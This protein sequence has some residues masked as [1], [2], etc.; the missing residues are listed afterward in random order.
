MKKKG[1]EDIEPDI[2]AEIIPEVRID[3]EIP[4]IKLSVK[5]LN[6]IKLG[7]YEKHTQLIRILYVN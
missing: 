6:L 7:K 5:A 4:D 2:P 1:K 3:N